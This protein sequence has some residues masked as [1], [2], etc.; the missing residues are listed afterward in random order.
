KS[1]G[2]PGVRE[3]G[4]RPETRTPAPRAAT[5]GWSR[6]NR[7]R[8][9]SRADQD[10]EARRG[11]ELLRLL[12]LDGARDFAVIRLRTGRVGRI[13]TRHDLVAARGQVDLPVRE[14][15]DLRERARVELARRLDVARTDEQEALLAFGDEHALLDQLIAG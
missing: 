15:V 5:P 10:Q 7:R 13:L 9:G 12:D 1:R 3:S 6:R 4:C 11:P 14:A 8:F 2:L